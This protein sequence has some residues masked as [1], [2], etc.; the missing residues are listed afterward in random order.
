MLLNEVEVVHFLTLLFNN[1]ASYSA[2]NTAR[3]A[4]SA[5]LCNDEG[6][7]IGK[8]LS[9]KRF[10]KGVFELRPPMPRYSFIWDVNIVLDYLKNLHP[11]ED[12]PL[13]FLS[14]KLVMLLALTTAQRAQ[15]LHKINVNNII[16]G[17]DLVVIPIVCLLKHS[18]PKN[19]K[20]TL[21]LKSYSECPAI[22]VVNA[23]KE[24]IEKTKDLRKNENPLFISYNRP[25]A[26]VSKDTISRWLK[27]VMEESGID[28][29]LFSAHS[30]RAASCSKAKVDEIHIDEILKTAGWSNSKTFEKFYNKNVLVEQQF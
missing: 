24:Y 30:T 2:I 10:L 12:M 16:F 19:R 27:R 4:L 20:M 8:F 21:N 18:T 25:H 3:S 7:V 26:A 1:G 13:S 17:N 6:L 29:D 5:I 23:L 22:C 14:V 9:V 11:N 28:I 15:T